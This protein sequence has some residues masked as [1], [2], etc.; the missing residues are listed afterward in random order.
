M[1][2]FNVRGLLNCLEQVQL[3]RQSCGIDI[4]AVTETWMKPEKSMPLGIRHESVCLEEQKKRGRRPGGVSLLLREEVSYKLLEKGGD[5]LIQYVAILVGD[6]AIVGVYISPE[7]RG[8]KIPRLLEFLEKVR[9]LT[10]GRLCI[11][12]DFNARHHTW[13][14][15][16][17][18][19]GTELKKWC[20]KRA[21]RVAAPNT[22]TFVTERGSSNVDLTLTRGC[23]VSWPRIP[24][25]KWDGCSDHRPVITSVKG[26]YDPREE[27]RGRISKA[28][29]ANE[30]ALAAAQDLVP[31]TMLIWT[32]AFAEVQ[33][34]EDAQ[35]IYDN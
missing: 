20:D 14:K 21:W 31:Q 5:N 6:L 16:S 28:R 17:N 33:S 3:L 1:G 18:Q 35:E 19:R 26:Q 12:G 10:P 24:K 7:V 23:A 8:E 30:K 11:L 13:D 27:V 29:L 32:R 4:L 34:E 15:G 2:T 9:R 25:G 22:P